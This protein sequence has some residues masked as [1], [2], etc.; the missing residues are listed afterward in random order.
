M[1]ASLIEIDTLV[2]PPLWYAHLG[3]RRLWCQEALEL[4]GSDGWIVLPGQD[5]PDSQHRCIFP[6]HGWVVREGDVDLV[7]K[8]RTVSEEKQKELG[9]GERLP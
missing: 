5:I 7:L 2:G 8:V 3:G 4:M 1:K 6:E 9:L